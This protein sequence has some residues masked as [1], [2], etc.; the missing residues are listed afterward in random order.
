MDMSLTCNTAWA[1]G[2]VT[3]LCCSIYENMHMLR[4]EELYWFIFGTDLW[5]QGVQNFPYRGLMFLSKLSTAIQL[6]TAFKL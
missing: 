6:W 4:S 3:P 5:K 2:T 1:A